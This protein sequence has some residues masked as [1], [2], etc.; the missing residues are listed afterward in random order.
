MALEEYTLPIKDVLPISEGGTGASSASEACANLGALPTAGGTITGNLGITQGGLY[1][2]Q[3][4]IFCNQSY[5]IYIKPCK[6]GED[7][8]KH[9]SL[10]LRRGDTEYRT[11]TV[12]FSANDGNQKTNAILWPDGR[13]TINN[14]NVDIINSK[15]SNYIRYENGIQ[16]VWGRI[17]YSGTDSNPIT[18]TFPVSFISQP[19]IFFG[20]GRNKS[21]D[22]ICSVNFSAKTTTTNSVV[23]VSATNVNG[24]IIY[25]GNVDVDYIVWGEYK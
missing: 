11:G 7:L 22:N 16:V 3:N 9:P 13:L 24:S 21:N 4:M 25:D 10:M 18:I 2:K 20:H 1:L 5:A 23:I 15:G 19:N 8:E 12:E 17:S 6:D 14:S